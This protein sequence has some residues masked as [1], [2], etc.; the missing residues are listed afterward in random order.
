VVQGIVAGVGFLCA[1]SLIK[2]GEEADHVQGLTTAASLWSAAA[3][4]A[5]AGLGRLMLALLATAFALAILAAL[6]KLERRKPRRPRD[7]GD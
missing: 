5:A 4:G 2:R 7:P 6:L 1:G 3:I